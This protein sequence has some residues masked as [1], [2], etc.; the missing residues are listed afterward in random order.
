MYVGFSIL[1]LSKF[2]MYEFHYKYI[3]RKFN[4]SLLFIDRD[5]SVYEAETEDVYKDLYEDKSL[6]DFGDYPQ[7]SF[8]LSVK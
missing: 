7:D 3:K 6:F 5:S 2:L 1:D 8:F 4:A